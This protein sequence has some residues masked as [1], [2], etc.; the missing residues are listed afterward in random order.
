MIEKANGTQM[1]EMLKASN[2]EG[3]NPATGRATSYRPVLSGGNGARVRKDYG[4]VPQMKSLMRM[5]WDEKL[6][7][8]DLAN[9]GGILK[10]STGSTKSRSDKLAELMG[11]FP[12]TSGLTAA[13]RIAILDAAQ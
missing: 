8:S 12:R 10:A 11:N 3:K 6:S 7:P 9:I 5:R 13:E 2:A 1:K 4:T